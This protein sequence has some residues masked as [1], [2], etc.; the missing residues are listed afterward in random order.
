VRRSAVRKNY[1]KL[2]Y[3]LKFSINM[4]SG[5]SRNFFGGVGVGCVQ[6]IQL[7]T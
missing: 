6:Q 3:D 5:V 7:R 1:V 4:A 2:F